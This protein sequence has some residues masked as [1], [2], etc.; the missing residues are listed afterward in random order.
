MFLAAITAMGLVATAVVL[1]RAHRRTWKALQSAD[2]PV[3]RRRFGQRQF[4]RRTTASTLMGLIGLAILVS[5][6]MHDPHQARFW[7]YWIGLLVLVMSMCLLALIDAVDT[8]RYFRAV[9]ATLLASHTTDS[10]NS[11]DLHHPELIDRL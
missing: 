6:A 9:H 4:R 3:P 7:L 2:V 8:L 1:L 11:D 10:E 5:P